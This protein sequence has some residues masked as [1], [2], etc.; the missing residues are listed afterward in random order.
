MREVEPAAW[1]GL[2]GELGLADAYY[3]RAYVE[4][5]CVLEPGEP[6]LLEH[7]GTVFAAILRD[8]AGSVPGGD[9]FTVASAAD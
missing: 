8:R 3:R 9:S 4:S 1:D 6:L 2:L 7:D 5:A